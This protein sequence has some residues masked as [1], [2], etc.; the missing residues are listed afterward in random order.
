MNDYEQ[1]EKECEQIRKKNAKL[2]G[3]FAAHL[4][5]EGLSP[6][7]VEKHRFNIDFY[8]NEFLLNDDTIE[9]EVGIGEISM[10]LGYW[11]IRKAASLSPSSIKANAVSLKKFYGWMA[12]IGKVDRGSVARMTAIIK[13]EMPIWTARMDRYNDSSIEDMAEI[14]GI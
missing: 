3:K 4:I 9:P 12:S 13:K 11:Y 14:W 7:T 1:W 10:Y 2:L 5:S 8:I 6:Q